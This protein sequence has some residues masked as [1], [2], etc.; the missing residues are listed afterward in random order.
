M[1]QLKQP[2][3]ATSPDNGSPKSVHAP[4]RP[5]MSM[6]RIAASPRIRLS[7][8]LPLILPVV[9]AVIAAYVQWFTVGLP[10]V[11]RF[12]NSRPRRRRN[13]MA[14]HPGS[15]L[16]TTLIFCLSF[17]LPVVGCKS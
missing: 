15:A 16:L 2:R 11:P 12:D 8:L 10:P 7:T 3:S 6:P 5:E 13:P 1:K 4:G 17:C 9:L 14:F